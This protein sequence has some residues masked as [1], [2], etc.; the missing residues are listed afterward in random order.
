MELWWADEAGICICGTL[1]DA[2]H[3][4]NGLRIFFSFFLFFLFSSFKKI[5][6]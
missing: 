2:F 3:R 4:L 5:N 6:I 1:T